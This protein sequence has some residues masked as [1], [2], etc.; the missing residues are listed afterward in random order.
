MAETATLCI[1][2]AFARIDDGLVHYRAV[3]GPNGRP[4][5][6]L[7]HAAPGG[8]SGL[9]HLMRALRE[10]DPHRHL[11]APDMLGHGDSEPTPH[12]TPDIAY[13]A[14]SM[15]QLLDRLGHGQVDL[16]GTH[17]GARIACEAALLAPDRVRTV[18][19]DGITDYDPDTR[20]LLLKRYAPEMQPD[21]YGR[22]FVW[23]FHFVRDMWIFFPH[24]ARDA[25][26]C[27]S[28]GVP[29]AETLHEAAMDVLRGLTSYHKAYLAAFAYE[30]RQRLKLVQQPCLF[31]S[32][33]G[34]LPQLQSSIAGFAGLMQNA[35]TA[36]VQGTPASTAT[37]MLR[38]LK[39]ITA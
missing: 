35:E 19:F 10:A 15:L 25:S 37:A 29:D 21:E 30:T 38:H 4:P 36:G 9:Q 16:Y 1:D 26:S 24:F 32:N 17:T 2:R 31:I 39:D 22:H 33:T 23:A 8:S 11:L 7:L 12:P 18:I 14:R 27:L 28:R 13:Y 3:G 34:E 6:V 5:L 20:T